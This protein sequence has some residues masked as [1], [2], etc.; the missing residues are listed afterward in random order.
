MGPDP[1]LLFRSA[2][3]LAYLDT[4]TYGLAP[5]PTTAAMR[6]ALAAWEAG[7]ARWIE[8]W[9]VVAEVA[10][11]DFAEIVGVDPAN[12]A[13]LPAASVGVGIVAASLQPNARIVVAENEFTSLLFPLLVAQQQGA[14]VTEVPIDQ[15]ADCI[16]PE[17]D[18]VAF[19]LVHMQTGQVA[20]AADIIAQAR[21]AGPEP[22]AL[23]DD[24]PLRPASSPRLSSLGLN[25][26]V[27]SKLCFS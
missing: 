20:P 24:H 1:S 15:L 6:H 21:A 11:R 26:C 9:D 23:G 14:T 2:E 19:S 25:G 18:L 12:V 17:T 8:D 3:G 7:T 16:D 13:L 4:A 27:R 10:R 22:G 5:L